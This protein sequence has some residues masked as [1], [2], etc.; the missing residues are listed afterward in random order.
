MKT[1]ATVNAVIFAIVCAIAIYFGLSP[2]KWQTWLLSLYAFLTFF[3]V[4]IVGTGNF[5]ESI[6]L[7]VLVT[8]ALILGGIATF[9]NRERAK[10]WLKEHHED[11]E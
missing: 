5:Y 1:V 4:G 2:K 3:L 11:E 7:G 8:S 6:K 10:R 9:W